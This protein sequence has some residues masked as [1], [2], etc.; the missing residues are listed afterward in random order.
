LTVL[1]ERSLEHQRVGYDFERQRMV[2]ARMIA[3]VSNYIRQSGAWLDVGF[4]NGSL[5]MTAQE[6]GFD[7]VGLDLRSN[8]VNTLKKLGIEAH[9]I[10][11]ADFKPAR[12]FS[13]ISMMDVL[14]HMPNPKRGLHQARRLL[15]SDGILFLSMP[16][17]KCPA[18]CILDAQEANPYWGELEHFH[19]FSRARLF[20]LLREVGFA[21]VSYGVSERYR[22]CMEVIARPIVG[23]AP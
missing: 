3:R 21:P 1:F 11:L 23:E 19:N 8:E 17:F 15:A 12:L 4:G 9:C 14:E 18:W 10:D 16:S 13:V 22:V 2:A 6:F 7:P 5:L 20:A